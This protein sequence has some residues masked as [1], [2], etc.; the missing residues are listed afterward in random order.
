MSANRL[1]ELPRPDCIN[2]GRV[3][4]SKRVAVSMCV[5]NVHYP[6]AYFTKDEYADWFM[7]TLRRGIRT[8]EAV[9]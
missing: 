4:G 3:P 6:I 2:I 8:E 1:N 7:E 5:G 9:K